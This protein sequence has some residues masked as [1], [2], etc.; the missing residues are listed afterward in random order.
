MPKFNPFSSQGLRYGFPNIVL[1]Y[2][3]Y[4]AVA[5]FHQNAHPVREGGHSC[6][7]LKHGQN[8]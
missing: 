4:G 7:I 3:T 6:H 5:R 1:E 2:L 8:A